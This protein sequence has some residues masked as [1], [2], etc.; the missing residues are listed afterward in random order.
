M[1]ILEEN[2]KKKIIKSFYFNDILFLDFFLSLNC[3]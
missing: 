1:K 3:Y 2:R